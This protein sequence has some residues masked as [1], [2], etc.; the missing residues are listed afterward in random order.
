M[1]RIRLVACA[2]AGLKNDINQ[3]PITKMRIIIPK[4]INRPQKPRPDNGKSKFLIKV[5]ILSIVK[6][7]SPTS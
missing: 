7:L 2:V 5:I 1:P 3:L 4:A 6:K